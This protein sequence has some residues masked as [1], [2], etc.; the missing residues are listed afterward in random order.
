LGARRFESE[1]DPPVAA[2]PRFRGIAH[3][4]AFV[5]AVPVGFVLVVH[6]RAGGAQAGAVVFAVSV[7]MMLG[8]SSL[9]HRRG[10]TPGRMRWIG[11]LDHAMIYVLIAGTYTPFAL[12][13]LHADWRLPILAVVWGGA[14]AATTG[15]LLRPDAPA[16]VSAATCVA[17]GWISLIILPQVVERIGVGAT[18][19]LFSGG[20]AYTAG[21]VVYARRRPD[22]FRHG[23]GFHEL[24]HVLVVVALACQYATIAF[25]VLPQA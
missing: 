2:K 15:R 4:V 7:T 3:L 19:L 21:A 24:F 10:W 5:A 14:V 12:L 23:F 8:V 11:H 16:G 9:F 6:A 20:V 17:L 13:V 22:P 18:S 1:V 25:F